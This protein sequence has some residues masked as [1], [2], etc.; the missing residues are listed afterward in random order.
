MRKKLPY[1]INYGVYA[2][3]VGVNTVAAALAADGEVR[4][5]VSTVSE[6]PDLEYPDGHTER[7]SLP[8]QHYSRP[9]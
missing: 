8:R 7:R 5:F 4:V 6:F 1:W 9:M 3:A 2:L